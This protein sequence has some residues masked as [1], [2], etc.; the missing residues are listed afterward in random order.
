LYVLPC[1]GYLTIGYDP[2]CPNCIAVAYKYF[3]QHFGDHKTDLVGK[4]NWNEEA[5]NEM[6]SDLAA[7]WQNLESTFQSSLERDIEFIKVL[8]DQAIEYIGKT[9]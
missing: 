7:P 3:C 9:E 4:H 8:M 6:V 5:I 2:G 1:Q